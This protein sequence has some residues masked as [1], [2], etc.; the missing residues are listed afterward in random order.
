MSNKKKTDYITGGVTVVI[1]FFVLRACFFGGD[2]ESKSLYEIRTDYDN[3]VIWEYHPKGLRDK[4]LNS[5]TPCSELQREFNIADAN[6]DRL[7]ATTGTGSSAI[8]GFINTQMEI[9]DCY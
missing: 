5:S 7:Y 3:R 6:S 1:L 4:I 8:M 2:G 9:R